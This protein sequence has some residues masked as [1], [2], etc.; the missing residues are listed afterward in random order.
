VLWIATRY[1]PGGDVRTLVHR[2]RPLPPTRAAAIFSPV[3][4]ALD[5][6]HAAGQVYRDVKPANMLLDTRQGRPDH[7]YLFDFG[8][9]KGWQGTGGLTGSGLFLGTLDY[10]A[11][12]Q[13]QG[14]AVDGRAD[15]YAL[16]C[17]AY[18]LL[19]GEPPFS[20]DQGLAVLY[21][22]LSAPPPSL[23]QRLRSLAPAVDVVLTRGLAKS[24]DQRYGSCGDFVHELRLALRR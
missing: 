16:A 11:P 5:A 7:V 14:L 4:S 6:A 8:L 24:A 13:I 18:E 21:A 20:R 23:T 22:Q 19:A 2:E 9:S 12:E 15:Q 17:A 1:V 3:A 10:A